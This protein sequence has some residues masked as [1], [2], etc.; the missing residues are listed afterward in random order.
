M[1]EQVD[2]IE[3]SASSSTPNIVA[4]GRKMSKKVAICSKCGTRV[5]CPSG[6]C[7]MGTCPLCG[8]DV[9]FK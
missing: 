5:K 4:R 6:D 7:E 9:Y 1:T 3:Y 2:K 8:W